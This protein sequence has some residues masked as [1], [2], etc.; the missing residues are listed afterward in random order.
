MDVVCSSSFRLSCLARSAC[1]VSSLSSDDVDVPMSTTGM[2]PTCTSVVSERCVAA[3]GP[4]AVG[5]LG[6]A[7]V[8]NVDGDHVLEVDAVCIAEN[9]LNITVLMVMRVDSAP[10]TM[11]AQACP[12]PPCLPADDRMSHNAITPRMM[13]G[14]PVKA[15]QQATET[16]P[17]TREPMAIPLVDLAFGLDASSGVTPRTLSG[18]QGTVMRSRCYPNTW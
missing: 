15:L 1:A 18:F 17:R 5:P 2:V 10:S 4:V 8:G 13:A 3:N 12:D 14:T 7:V 6:G 11:P 9:T 16:Q